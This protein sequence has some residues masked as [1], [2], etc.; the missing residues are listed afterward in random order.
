MN[1][2]LRTEYVPATPFIECI[3]LEINNHVNE[4]G[5]QLRHMC[6]RKFGAQRKEEIRSAPS[7]FACLRPDREAPLSVLKRDDGTMTGNKQEMDQILRNKWRAIF[8]KH[9]A[10]HHPPGV[11]GFLNQ[12]AQCNGRHQMHIKRVKTQA[13][14]VSTVGLL[15]I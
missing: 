10:D 3:I 2:L 5:A 1:L 9:S 6:L 4:H 14:E 12:Y 15:R 13:R 7:A 11:N 8:C